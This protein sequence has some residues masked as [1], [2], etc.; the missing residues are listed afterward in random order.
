[1]SKNNESNNKI[2][3]SFNYL[4]S[5]LEKGEDNFND[6]SENKIEENS[7]INDFFCNK[8]CYNKFINIIQKFKEK[9]IDL[10]K[11]DWGKYSSNDDNIIVKLVTY[12]YN[13]GLKNSN[14]K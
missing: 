3:D 2:N 8:E 13:L 1:M 9:K 11:I 4:L 14:N 12:Y 7:F 6:K 5:L 10:T